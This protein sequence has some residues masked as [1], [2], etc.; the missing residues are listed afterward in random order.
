[1]VFLLYI[2][3]FFDFF[4]VFFVQ[5]KGATNEYIRCLD[6]ACSTNNKTQLHVGQYGRKIDY[7]YGIVTRSA[8]QAS[9]S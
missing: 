5:K 2:E 4:L 3:F 9:F 6:A 8:L 1:M 7:D